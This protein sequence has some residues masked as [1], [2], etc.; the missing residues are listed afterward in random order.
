VRKSLQYPLTDFLKEFERDFMGID[1]SKVELFIDLDI[2]KA[3][4][5]LA[6]LKQPEQKKKFKRILYVVLQNKYDESLYR[7]EEVSEKANGV[8]AMKFS[9]KL[10]PRIYCKEFFQ[11]GVKRVVMTELLE[12]KDFQKASSKKLKP[13]LESIGEYT[14][15]FTK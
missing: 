10:N 7:K 5:I 13:R 9:G 6:F 15:E 4:P 3:K 1:T 8:T 11:G 2:R 12:N 14:Y